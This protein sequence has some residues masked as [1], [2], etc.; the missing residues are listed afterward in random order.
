MS[1]VADISSHHLSFSF[2]KIQ[3]THFWS[4]NRYL[5]GPTL[6]VIISRVSLSVTYSSTSRRTLSRM[7]T[8]YR[9]CSRRIGQLDHKRHLRN[10]RRNR[11]KSSQRHNYK[12]SLNASDWT[13]CERN[14]SALVAGTSGCI[15]TVMMKRMNNPNQVTT[16]HT[17]VS[18]RSHE[19]R[20]WC[21]RRR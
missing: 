20:Y 11:K 5:N 15:V 1:F 16:Q 13:N 2:L 4:S 14:A 12:R 18:E 8:T 6:L 17:Q 9:N 7:L 10:T 19:R 21:T 3:L